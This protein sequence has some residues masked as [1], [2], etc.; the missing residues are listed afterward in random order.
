MIEEQ[1]AE[2]LSRAENLA[3]TVSAPSLVDCCEI[4]QLER[5]GKCSI[6]ALLI[7]C[8]IGANRALDLAAN[9]GELHNQR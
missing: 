5:A 6:E 8:L 4:K 2:F 1:P 3:S 7:P 9:V